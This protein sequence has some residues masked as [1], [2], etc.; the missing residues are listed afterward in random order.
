VFTTD[1]TFLFK[2]GCVLFQKKKQV[3]EL[4]AAKEV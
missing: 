3:E 4:V 2:G 1:I